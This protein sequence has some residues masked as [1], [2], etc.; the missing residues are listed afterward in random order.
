MAFNLAEAAGLGK[1]VSKMDTGEIR[2]IPLHEI[3][4]TEKTFSRLRTCRISWK[5]SRCTVSYS[6][7][8]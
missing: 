7:W 8:S 2:Q 1:I 5:P 4:K 3:D 6:R